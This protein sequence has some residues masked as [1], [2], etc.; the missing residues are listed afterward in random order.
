MKY[1][2][3]LM[4]R[5]AAA[6]RRG[7]LI[8]LAVVGIVTIAV[9]SVRLLAGMIL[10]AVVP[11]GIA[12]AVLLVAGILVLVLATRLGKFLKKESE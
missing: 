6:V 12:V 1:L 2:A 8:L 4:N 9:L 3:N 11:V 10:L 7:I 5:L